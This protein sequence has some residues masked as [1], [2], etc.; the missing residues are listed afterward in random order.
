VLR[1]NNASYTSCD[2]TIHRLAR[3]LAMASREKDTCES[4]TPVRTSSNMDA[5]FA[6]KSL[7]CA[8]SPLHYRCKCSSFNYLKEYACGVVMVRGV[9]KRSS[10][11]DEKDNINL[12]RRLMPT[13]VQ[14]SRLQSKRTTD[15]PSFLRG[16]NLFL[17]AQSGVYVSYMEVK[18]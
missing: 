14:L 8:R 6:C 11:G 18:R 1:S 4:C 10:C 17:F 5:Q 12:I 3:L 9:Y 16:V 7:K 15:E 13:L 2:M